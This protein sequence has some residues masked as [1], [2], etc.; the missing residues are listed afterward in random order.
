MMICLFLKRSCLG[1]KNST[2]T[3][4]EQRGMG[5][6]GDLNVYV[7]SF[8]VRWR[9]FVLF[10]SYDQHKY[11]A[12]PCQAWSHRRQIN[13]RIKVD[14]Q[15]LCAALALKQRLQTYSQDGR[16]EHPA[17][18]SRFTSNVG[19]D[20]CCRLPHPL[21]YLLRRTALSFN[22]TV[23]MQVSLLDEHNALSDRALPPSQRVLHNSKPPSPPS[24]DES[25][26]PY[27]Q[28]RN[29]FSYLPSR[30]NPPQTERSNR[31]TRQAQT[32]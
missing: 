3:T 2:M 19:R 27:S 1:N 28:Q 16:H 21:S 26:V 18:D 8:L 14:P 23:P 10:V 15:S 24:I 22:F 20:V 25:P 29:R 13:F 4:D 31:H 12:S 7:Q 30:T 9:T 5:L 17:L 6:E 32:S 11:H